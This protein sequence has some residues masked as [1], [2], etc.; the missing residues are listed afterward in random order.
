MQRSGSRCYNIGGFIF[1][2]ER[3]P[4]CF[5]RTREDQLIRKTLS[6]F[7][8]SSLEYVSA[9]SSSHSLSEAVL[10][11]SLSLLGLVCSEHFLHLLDIRYYSA[12]Q[13]GSNVGSVT[14]PFLP[15]MATLFT[16][17]SYIIPDS[18]WFVKCFLNFS[19]FI[20]RF[21]RF[22]RLLLR[23]IRKYPLLGSRCRN[24]EGA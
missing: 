5:F 23:K 10:L 12:P 8:A 14:V 15:P 3:P 16:M 13:S 6:A 22:F 4:H 19:S 7:C 18:Y 24:R 20:T 21:M 11:L 2:A 1:S 9:V 17:T